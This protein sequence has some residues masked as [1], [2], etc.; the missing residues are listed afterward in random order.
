V[1]G[2]L[3]VL[4]GIAGFVAVGQYWERSIC[5]A[6]SRSCIPPSALNQSNSTTIVVGSV[7]CTGVLVLGGAILF[8]AGY[9]PYPPQSGEEARKLGRSSQPAPTGVA[10]ATPECD[11]S[12]ESPGRVG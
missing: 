5:P 11:S 9:F 10:P 8:V 1:L 4:S 6:A 2:T 7:A 12:D 3:L